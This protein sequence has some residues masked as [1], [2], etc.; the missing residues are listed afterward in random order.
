MQNA[1]LK[2]GLLPCKINDLG[3]IFCASPASATID[4]RGVKV[5]QCSLDSTCVTLSADEDGAGHDEKRGGSSWRRR[6]R[7]R[8]VRTRKR[9]E[10]GWILTRV[11]ELYESGRATMS[12]NLADEL[13]IKASGSASGSENR[14][15]GSGPVNQSW[16]AWFR[17]V[18]LLLAWYKNW[19][20]LKGT[21]FG[22]KAQIFENNF[23]NCA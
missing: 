1:N 14:T 5:K 20:C 8:S 2:K 13:Q 12:L 18:C 3:R 6:R 16:A 11:V 22:L 21:K 7:R 19:L 23:K 15:K 10:D 17:A 4:R 9:D